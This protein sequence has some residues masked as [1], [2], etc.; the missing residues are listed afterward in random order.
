MGFTAIDGLP[1]GTRAG[2]LDPGVVL[3]LMEELGMDAKAVESLLYRESG[4]L[5]VSGVSSDMRELLASDDPRAKFAIELF[6]YRISRELG[7]L[8]AAL[9][10]LDAIVFTAGIGERAAPIRHGVCTQSAW[11]GIEL[12]EAANERS[13]ARISTP[14]S[15]VAAW[16]L[17]T[18]EELM[19]ARHT[20][21]IVTRT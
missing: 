12:D 20:Y 1:M 8:A 6:T 13:D 14:D 15:R 4:L 7:S 21:D 10:G 18:N 11:L 5:G 17:P 2:N 3:Y 9:G 16:V 19:I